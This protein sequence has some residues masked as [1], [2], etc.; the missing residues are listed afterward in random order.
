[1]TIAQQIR[2]ARRDAKRLIGRRIEHV[3]VQP[4][5]D[6][7]VAEPVLARVAFDMTFY[8]DDGS[9]FWFLPAETELGSGLMMIVR[10]RKGALA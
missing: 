8:L 9:A 5:N 2:K 10:T 7:D 3:K 1:M 4:I 6:S